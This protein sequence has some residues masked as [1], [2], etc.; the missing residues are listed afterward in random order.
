MNDRQKETILRYLG[1]V[2]MVVAAT[3][4]RAVV[5]PILDDR[6]PFTA[7]LVA[8][9]VAAH[10]CG[11]APSLLTLFLGAL[12]S[13]YFFTS[14]RESIF[15]AGPDQQAS[16]AL[17]ILFGLFVAFVMRNGQRAKNE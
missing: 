7:Y 16:F 4:I 1:A 9:I 14:P 15:I 12:A 2:A 10:F 11:F 6:Q 8:V 13:V 5:D 17:F 3:A